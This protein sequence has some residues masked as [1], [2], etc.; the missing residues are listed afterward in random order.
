MLSFPI[1][2]IK[3]VFFLVALLLMAPGDN[4]DLD[5]CIQQASK[6]L[7]QAHGYT[8]MPRTIDHDKAGWHTV[9]IGDWTSGFWPG[10]L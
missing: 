5:Y 2:K 4:K 3:C 10:I 7:A 1:I 8:Q 9:G 6:T